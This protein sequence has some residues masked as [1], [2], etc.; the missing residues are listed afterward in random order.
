M[1]YET[2]TGGLELVIPTAGTTNWATNLKNSTWQKIN[3]H[4]HTGS[5]DGN[6]LIGAS[7]TDNSITK[8]QLSKN[9]AVTQQTLTPSGTTETIDWNLGNKV[10]LDLSSATG[11]VTL[12]INNPIEGANY[13]IKVIQGGTLRL[14]VWPAAVKWQ[15]GQEPSQFMEINTDN[16]IDLDHDGTSYYTKWDINLS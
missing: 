9:I 5:G 2:L 13:R 10:I 11:T 16:L 6:Q 12:T 7:L 4:Q 3:D 15:D 1:G 8:L 14:L